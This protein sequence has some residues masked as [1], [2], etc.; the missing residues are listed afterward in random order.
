SDNAHPVRDRL[1]GRVLDG[2]LL[3]QSAYRE[4][5]RG[6]FGEDVRGRAVAALIGSR[7]GRPR[8][9]RGEIATWKIRPTGSRSSGSS[10]SASPSRSTWCS[11][12]STSGSASCFPP[13]RRKATATR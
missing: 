6:R 1:L 5:A 8:S 11:T 7:R 13:I 3:H 12:D 4:G 10:F 2:H 9:H